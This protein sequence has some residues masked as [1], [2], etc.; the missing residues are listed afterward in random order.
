MRIEDVHQVRDSWF[1]IRVAAE[2]GVGGVSGSGIA[3]I[4]GL[5]DEYLARKF[6]SAYL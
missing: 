2:L 6:G 5:P 3:E 1:A 4:I